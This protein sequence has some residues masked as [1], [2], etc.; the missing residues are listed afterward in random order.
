VRLG[1][2][3]SNLRRGGGITHLREILRAADAREFGFDEVVVW[4]GRAT[5]DALPPANDWLR[6][7]HVPLLDGGLA[8]RAWWQQFGLAREAARERCDLLFVPGGSYLGAFRPFV[9]MSRNMLPFEPHERAR[10]GLS[11]MRAKFTLLE[12]VQSA[13]MLRADGVIFLND[14][15]RRRVE[16]RAGAMRGRTAVIPHGVDDAF[17]A[18]PRPQ[19]P[20]DVFSADR[21]FRLLYVSIVD[22]YK[23]QDKVAE[24]VGRLR[25]RGVPV[26]IDFRGPEYAPAARQLR[27]VVQR[28]DPGGEFVRVDGPVAYSG[29]PAAYAAA[30]AFVF[31]SSCENMPNILLEAMAS[32]LPIASSRRGPMPEILGEAGVYFDPENV[33]EIEAALANL[34]AD[35]AARQSWAAAA[36]GRAGEFSWQRCAE[37]TYRFLAE[38]AAASASATGN[39]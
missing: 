37:Q 17:R 7:Q 4:S 25:R 6:L 21:P 36:F 19:Q 20:I 38:I 11:L 35:R 12:Y 8:Q 27:E 13:S 18:A 32:G 39:G 5:L 31:A 29:L 26:T 2:E 3:A 9:T 33:D 10:Y 28:V 22:L 16:E 24:A 1:I 34:V 30:D 15:A 14:Y 23:H